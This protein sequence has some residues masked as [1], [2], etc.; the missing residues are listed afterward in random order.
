[1]LQ[2]FSFCPR[3][4]PAGPSPFTRSAPLR[5][6]A[7]STSNRVFAAPSIAEEQEETRA[8][9]TKEGDPPV[10]RLPVGSRSVRL[11]LLWS[12]FFLGLS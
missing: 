1:M 8:R 6:A 12:S 7:L 10:S 3:L 4:E 5:R 11:G 2:A 9:E